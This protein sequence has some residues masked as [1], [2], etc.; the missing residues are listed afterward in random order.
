MLR[1]RGRGRERKRE[2]EV[3]EG[4]GQRFLSLF[5]PLPAGAMSKFYT[6]GELNIQINSRKSVGGADLTA[7]QMEELLALH[8]VIMQRIK[9]RVVERR[10][11]T[12]DAELPLECVAEQRSRTE[13]PMEPGEE[14][15]ALRKRQ[16]ED[17]SRA[18]VLKKVLAAESATKAAARAAGRVAK[19][20]EVAARRAERAAGPKAKRARAV[21]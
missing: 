2:E 21:V 8:L 20:A 13:L 18:L 14:L 1:L 17:R 19:A 16:L 10:S 7:E 9:S 6:L 15:A 3:K 4:E 11:R 5:V 12:V